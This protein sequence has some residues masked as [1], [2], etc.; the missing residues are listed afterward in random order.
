MCHNA[1]LLLLI[2]RVLRSVQKAI[3][4]P[5]YINISISNSDERLEV[6]EIPIRNTVKVLI[7]YQDEYLFIDIAVLCMSDLQFTL[8]K[9]AYIDGGNRFRGLV[10]SSRLVDLCQI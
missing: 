10:W 8:M 7:L 4:T 2:H 9:N 5:K 6:M 3:K 1:F